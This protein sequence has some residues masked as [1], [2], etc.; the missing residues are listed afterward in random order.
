M[1]QVMSA[2]EVR[3]HFG[4]VMQEVASKGEPVI[5]ERGGKPVVAVISL[6]DL[7]RLQELRSSAIRP[8]NQA[9]LDWLDEWKKTPDPAGPEWWDEFER[10]LEQDP[11]VL[12]RDE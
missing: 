12:G 11:V 6:A 5:V 2:T 10:E 8:A 4:R 7:E 1:S 3:T 9:A